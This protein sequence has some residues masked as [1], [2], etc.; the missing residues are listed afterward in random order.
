MDAVELVEEAVVAVVV[1][2][3]MAAPVIWAA[4]AVGTAV[5]AEAVMEV[6][7][8]RATAATALASDEAASDSAVVALM[9]MAHEVEASPSAHPLTLLCPAPT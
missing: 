9:L 5:E 2:K 6:K 3:A 4:T 7:V 1:V 8:G